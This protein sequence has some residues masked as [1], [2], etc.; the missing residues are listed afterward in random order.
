[1][2]YDTKNEYRRPVVTDLG[3]MKGYECPAAF[4][5]ERALNSSSSGGETRPR[6]RLKEL[7][8]RTW[9]CLNWDRLIRTVV[10]YCLSAQALAATVDV[11]EHHQQDS[12]PHSRDG[13]TLELF[14]LPG[15]DYSSNDVQKI[16]NI[17]RE[18]AC[19][20]LTTTL[21]QDARGV[22]VHF[23]SVPVETDLT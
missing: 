14:L 11:V 12:L 16:T 2:H 13:E 3:W 23:M 1:M 5:M 18:R 17:L 9:R 19:P 15:D 21:A 20:A 22:S 7:E 6:L 8:L 10:T 4:Q